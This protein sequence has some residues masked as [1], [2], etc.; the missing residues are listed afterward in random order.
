MKR[1]LLAPLFL[2][3]LFAPQDSPADSLCP[4]PSVEHGGQCVLRGD[5]VLSATMWIPSGPKLNCQGPR[6]TPVTAGI[7]DDPRPPT[8]EFQPSQPELAMVV[9]R[10]YDVK[11]Q[12]CVIS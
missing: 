3:V 10:S 5:A 11:I 1:S 7:L 2:V 8:N 4:S 9:H 12:N 6:L